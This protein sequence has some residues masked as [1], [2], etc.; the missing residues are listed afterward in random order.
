MAAADHCAQLLK[1][2]TRRTAPSRNPEALSDVALEHHAAALERVWR[3]GVPAPR[4]EEAV[5]LETEILIA[6]AAIAR[7][8]EARDGR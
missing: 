7:R 5:T 8:Q 2:S 4:D 3:L 6:R 1:L